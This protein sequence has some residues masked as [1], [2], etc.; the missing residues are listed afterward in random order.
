[1]IKKVLQSDKMATCN[2]YSTATSSATNWRRKWR[3]TF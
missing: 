1:M 2:F 3:L